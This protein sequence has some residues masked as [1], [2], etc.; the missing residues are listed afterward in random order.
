MIEIILVASVIFN[1][2][3]MWY[4]YLLLRKVIYVSGNTSEI[5]GAVDKYRDHLNGV[6]E[7]EMF[8]GD[9]TLQSLLEHTSDL[10]TFLGECEQAYGMTESEYGN[11]VE[12]VQE[13]EAAPDEQGRG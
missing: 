6:F 8:Y 2:A 13:E 3:L 7:L 9:E 5:I 10:S 1:L 11:Y 12:S 4:G